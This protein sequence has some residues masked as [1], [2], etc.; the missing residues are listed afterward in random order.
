V[1]VQAVLNLRENRLCPQQRAYRDK[2]RTSK[3]RKK[4]QLAL[5]RSTPTS[6]LPQDTGEE[7]RSS[8]TLSHAQRER[9]RTKQ[10]GELSF[11]PKTRGAEPKPGP[12][13]LHIL[14]PA[15]HFSSEAAPLRPHPRRRAPPAR[16]KNKPRRSFTYCALTRRRASFQDLSC[17]RSVSC[18]FIPPAAASSAPIPALLLRGFPPTTP[19]LSPTLAPPRPPHPDP[20]PLGRGRGH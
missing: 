6:F 13:P 20:L 2:T 4:R 18:R 11:E 5:P 3:R 9:E 16:S 10:D 1:G 19:L 17:E 12:P 8:F 14:N 15:P 7:V